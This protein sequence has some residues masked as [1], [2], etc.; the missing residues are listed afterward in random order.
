[1]GFTP[2]AFATLQYSEVDLTI[3]ELS[4]IKQALSVTLPKN[5]LPISMLTVE[6]S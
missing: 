6:L 4:V 3:G 5:H 1:M 2:Q